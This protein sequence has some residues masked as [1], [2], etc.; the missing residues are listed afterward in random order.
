MKKILF[1]SFSIAITLNLLTVA[2]FAQTSVATTSMDIP[3]TTN[4]T[5]AYMNMDQ[6]VQAM[7]AY[8]KAQSELEA[9]AKQQ[10]Q[11]LKNKAEAIKKYEE[12]VI[13]QKQAGTL[14]PKDEQEAQQKSQK[15]RTSLQQDQQKAQQLV[16]QKEQVLMQPVEQ[17]FGE[18]I[19]A[20]AKANGYAYIVDAKIFLYI[21]GG[22]DATALIKK[23]LGLAP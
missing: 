11:H 5:I 6:I 17:K 12:G 20:V 22:I 13:Q 9:Y 1:L 10:Q 23:Q 3:T 15:M 4:T 2:V 8:K 14:A 21:K 18:A 7:P 19:D 16:A